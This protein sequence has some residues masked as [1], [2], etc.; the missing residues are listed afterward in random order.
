MVFDGEYELLFS[1]AF[2][3]LVKLMLRPK[4]KLSLSVKLTI[5]SRLPY[6]EDFCLAIHYKINYFT[7]KKILN[8]I[9]K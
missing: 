6:I 7:I 9:Q 3:R 2:K 4:D 1:S 8:H 5:C